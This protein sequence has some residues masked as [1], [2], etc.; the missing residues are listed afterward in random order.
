[1]DDKLR[2]DLKLGRELYAA[3]DFDAALPLLESVLGTGGFADVYNMIGVIRWQRG[4]RNAAIASFEQA[5]EENPAYTEAVLNLAVCY[6]ESERYEEARKLYAGLTE[7]EHQHRDG[8]LDSYVRGKIANLH[9]ELSAAY[10]GV[11]RL[12]AATSELKKALALCP[13]FADLRTRLG[14]ILRERGEHAAAID[15]LRAARDSAP[16]YLNARIQLGITLW[17]ADRLPE[18]E[19]EWNAA[20]EQ[21]PDNARCTAYLKMARKAASS[22]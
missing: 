14:V 1:M 5:T 18:A 22:A 19:V 8:Q 12:E 15:E 2:S 4:E 10:R 11:G 20:L 3:G 9:A 17:A 7:R 16:E 6:N 13:T 21:D